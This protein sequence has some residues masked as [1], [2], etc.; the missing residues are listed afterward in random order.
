M[1]SFF[2]RKEDTFDYEE[3]RTCKCCNNM[4]KGRYCNV[5]GEKVVEPYERSLLGFLDNVLNAFTFLDGKFLTSLKSLISK[6]GLL[7]R[8]IADG[9]RVPYMKMVSLFFL[10]NF[11]Y[12]LFPFADS[13]NSTLYTQMNLMGN[14][15]IHA[16]ARVDKELE[17]RQISLEQF[18]EKY[19]AQSTNLSKL[20]LVVLVLVMTVVLMVTNFSKKN[21]FFDHLLVSLEFYSFHLLI[22]MLLFPMILYAF[23][24]LASLAGWDW[25]IVF[26]D[27]Y[28]SIP[29]YGLL[30]YFLVRTQRNFYSQ[31]WYWAIPK[32]LLI[33]YLFTRTVD[34]YREFL[35][36]ATVWTI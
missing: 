4:F 23:V 26:A 18:R 16:K 34:L 1:R 11:F 27:R 36:Y 20:L 29:I 25:R 28:F 12:F 7:S 21:Y 2:K 9:K 10:A 19:E 30:I 33:F 5:C 35:F 31:K 24:Y 13:F 6:P 17:K 32:S 14:H 15:S 3:S 22:N 8:N